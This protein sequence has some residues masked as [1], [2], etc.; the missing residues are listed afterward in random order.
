MELEGASN[1]QSRNGARKIPGRPIEML[2]RT[3]CYCVLL[4]AVVRGEAKA[5][6]TVS[7]LPLM[8]TLVYRGLS[9]GSD[10]PY[11]L[12]FAGRVAFRAASR[13]YV[14]FL[15]GSWATDK[16]IFVRDNSRVIERDF[17]AVEYIVYAQLYVTGGVFLRG[18]GGLG[19]TRTVNA[20]PP[21]QLLE[22]TG[23]YLP[24]VSAGVGFEIPLSSLVALSLSWDFTR[25]LRSEG[26]PVE[27]NRAAQL[28]LGLTIH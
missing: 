1:W 3:M 10:L 27:L 4:L 24:A 26:P 20:L 18:G 17:Q 15:V 12:R 2:T 22:V 16:S 13:T 25:L 23:S 6:D 21:H 5:Q 7:S 9:H 19:T 8:G 11:A 28:G 14:G